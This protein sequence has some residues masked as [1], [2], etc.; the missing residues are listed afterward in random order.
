MEIIF[1]TRNEPQLYYFVN[2][3]S[4]QVDIE[5]VILEKSSDWESWWETFY[6]E[7]IF[8]VIDEW[9]KTTFSE[10]L[11]QN[12]KKNYEGIFD[13]DWKQL[14]VDCEV[15]EVKD[16]NLPKTQTLIQDI[17]PD[18][19]LVHGTSIITDPILNIPEHAINLHWGLTPYYRG[20][21]S[22]G[23]ALINWDTNNIGV[24]FHEPTKEIDGG[25][26]VAQKRIKPK[27][28]DTLHSL[29]MRLVKKSVPVIFKIVRQL[30]N[31][32]TLN[33]KKQDLSKGYLHYYQHWDE[34][35]EDHLQKLEQDE[36]IEE[37]INNPSREELPIKTL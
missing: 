3:I 16:I 1:L 34:S 24:T 31:Q 6:T 32:G 10:I 30:K 36:V 14:N 11:P 5:H 22:I 25:R 29:R 18:L 28:G 7:N 21:H 2:K 20:A 19:M 8:T 13:D 33:Y 26:I 27:P 37:M 12:K 17:K 15:T 4:K 9:W 23:W 35:L